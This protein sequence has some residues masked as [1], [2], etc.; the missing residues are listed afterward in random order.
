MMTHDSPWCYKILTLGVWQSQ[1]YLHQN[2]DICRENLSAMGCGAL[3][4]IQTTLVRFWCGVD[5]GCQLLQYCLDGSSV[6]VSSLH[7]LRLI[8][9]SVSVVFHCWS[10]MG[11]GNGAWTQL[12]RNT[13]KT[14]PNLCLTY[15]EVNT[16]ANICSFAWKP[17]FDHLFKI[18]QF[19]Y[20]VYAF[21][22]MLLQNGEMSFSFSYLQ[23]TSLF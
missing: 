20:F 16:G 3:V 19:I 13:L 8:S 21:V 17:I 14:R 6:L 12:T 2:F 10:N 7:C 9:S 4:A 18:I 1:W 23:C 22:R 11:R 15:G 5:C